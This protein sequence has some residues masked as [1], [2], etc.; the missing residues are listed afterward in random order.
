M[1]ARLVRTAEKCKEDKCARDKNPAVHLE[2]LNEHGV[3]LP[4]ERRN[5]HNPG[6]VVMCVS[7]TFPGYDTELRTPQ[8]DIRRQRNA[9]KHI[10]GCKDHHAEVAAMTDARA[11]LLDMSTVLVEMINGQ[12]Y[13]Y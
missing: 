9:S 11:D 4:N 10:N 1:S 12:C 6:I 5:L 2:P 8:N 3:V 13:D 7:P